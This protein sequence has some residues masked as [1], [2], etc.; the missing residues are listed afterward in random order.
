MSE[1][2]GQVPPTTTK[3][4]RL[5]DLVNLG[6]TREFEYRGNA[7]VGVP[8]D[9]I[10][11]LGA[12]LALHDQ[13]KRIADRPVGLN[14]VLTVLKEIK[15]RLPPPAPPPARTPQQE[16]EA[17]SRVRAWQA[18]KR[19]GGE[20]ELDSPENAPPPAT[21]LD[22]ELKGLGFSARA[23]QAF[24]RLDITTLRE[25]VTKTGDDLLALR[26]FGPTTL[27]EISDKLAE[28]GLKLAEGRS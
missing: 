18:Y 14:A 27:I 20:M 22:T 9:A 7:I 6:W 21:P 23:R 1:N 13:I 10:I 24:S 19:A 2:N 17:L 25:L 12:L 26:N 4:I 8:P 28:R 3:R 16:R 5:T 15:K 11:G